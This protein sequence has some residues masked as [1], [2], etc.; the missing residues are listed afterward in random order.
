VGQY[1]SLVHLDIGA[2]IG[3][4][5]GDPWNIDDTVQAGDPA[6][7][8]Q[9]ADT[10][11]LAGA[12][13]GEADLAFVD[14]KKR[15]EG[16]WNRETGEHP[17]NDSAELQAL[18]RSIFFQKAQL[19]QIAADLESV[20][21]TLAEAQRLSRADLDVLDGQLHA[22]DALIDQALPNDQDVSTLEQ[23]AITITANTLQAVQGLRDEY[24]ETLSQ[25]LT[26]VRADGYDPSSLTGVDG[27]GNQTLDE[28]E[29][30]VVD[31]YDA[32]QRGRDQALVESG[33]PMTAA[34]A[35]AAA[36][37]RDGAVADDP[38]ADPIARHLASERLDDFATAN[39]VGPL[40]VDPILGGTVA[41]RARGRLEMQRRL[42]Q[43][44]LG[45]PMNSDQATARID[46]AEAASR[47]LVTQRAIEALQREGATAEGAARAVS[48]LGEGVP[49]RQI[50]D[51][52]AALLSAAGTAVDAATRSVPTNLHAV[53]RFS[54][55]DL[56]ALKG[57]SSKLGWAGV[58][59][60]AGI[61]LYDVIE[62]DAPAWRT[63]GEV[64]GS[65]VGGYAT[66]VAAWALAGSLIGPEGAVLTGLVGA[67]VLSPYFTKFGGDLLGALDN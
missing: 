58:G 2:L 56:K 28:R 16:S 19:P 22:V 63:T 64:A 7:I 13:I 24:S 18:T 20:A 33:G 12:C 43:G 30:S 53:D 54:E 48:L 10:F 11:R 15:F 32:D 57:V 17:I 5:G 6:E 36:R 61:G 65:A 35:E 27:D 62:N 50:I 4:A 55:A 34:K 14:A 8:A 25:S 21:A 29:K 60:D 51:H 31:T 3:G 40:P 47:V 49:W 23:D 46:D 66:G 1:P 39:F 9:L 42:E 52:D 38:N 44:L 59:V 45:P 26:T 67:V 41:D 37:L